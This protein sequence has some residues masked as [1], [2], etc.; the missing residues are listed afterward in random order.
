MELTYI[1]N[2]IV[3]Q[4]NGKYACPH[5]PGCACER[6]NCKSCGWNP[7]VDKARREARAKGGK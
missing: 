3:K 7:S 1:K 5:N 4:K 2:D 6:M